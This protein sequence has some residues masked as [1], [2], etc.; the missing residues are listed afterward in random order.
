MFLIVGSV[1]NFTHFVYFTLINI[2]TLLLII[3][4]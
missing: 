2:I 3:S 1:K 4:M